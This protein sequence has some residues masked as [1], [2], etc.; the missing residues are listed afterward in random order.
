[1]YKIVYLMVFVSVY[2]TFL[3]C[4]QDNANVST[5]ELTAVTLNGLNISFDPQNGNIIKLSYPETGDI[6]IADAENAGII[7]IS[8]AAENGQT[9]ELLP[10]FSGKAQITQIES[11]VKIQWRNL[12]NEKSDEI[13]SPISTTVIFKT[14]PEDNSI[15]M[16]CQIENQSKKTIKQV[17]FPDF[18][19]IIAFD[20]RNEMQLTTSTLTSKPFL[21]LTPD[22]P[23]EY[24]TG[25]LVPSDSSM[26]LR[27]FD[28]GSLKRGISI[29]PKRW[30][31]EPRA[32]L[33]QVLSSSTGKLQLSCVHS[34]EVAPGGCWQ[35]CEYVLTPHKYGWANGVIPYRKWIRKN[36]KQRWQLPKHIAEDIGFR[37]L[38]MNQ[39]QPYD[40]QDAT[41][42]ADDL[43]K[44]AQESK[45]HGLREMVLWSWAPAFELPIPKP[46]AIIGTEQEFF[47]AVKKCREMGVD[48]S[49][50]ISF[51]L[52]VKKTAHKYGVKFVL[53]DTDNWTYHPELVPMFRPPYARGL[54]GVMVPRTNE[55]WRRE[56]LESCAA[57]SEKGL[58]IGW[59]VF[60]STED[61]HLLELIQ[62]VRETAKQFDPNSTL[63]GEEHYNL[64][65][66]C[67]YLDYTWNWSHYWVANLDLRPVVNILRP[68]MR[69]NW[70]INAS[71]D[72]TKYC[73]INN[74]FVNVW[75]S[76]L[77]GPDGTDYIV[78][79]PELSGALKQCSKLRKQF[80]EYFIDGTGIADC[81]LTNACKNANISAYVLP[82]SV[83][84]FVLNK[85]NEQ[86]IQLQCDVSPWIGKDGVYTVKKYNGDGNVIDVI[87][88]EKPDINLE[89]GVLKS[90]DI[91]LY[92]IIK[93]SSLMA[94]EKTVAPPTNVQ[95]TLNNINMVF[96]SQTGGIL[97][98]SSPEVGTFISAD[99]KQACIFDL[100][101]PIEKFEPLRVAP[102]FSKDVKITKN[103]DSITL[104]WGELTSS[105]SFFPV[106]GKI[107]A[108][109][110]LKV[111]K[112]DKSII[113][114][115]QINNQ[116]ENTIR[117][118]I[119]PDFFGVVPL[120]ASQ[121]G[122]HTTADI[123]S[124][125]NISK[126]FVLMHPLADDNFYAVR[127]NFVQYPCNTIIPWM[128][129][130][131]EKGGG[132]AVFSKKLQKD[133]NDII[134]M[135]LLEKTLELR[136]MFSH[137]VNIKAGQE[138]KSGDYYLT[139][140]KYGW[141]QNIQS[142]RS[143]LSE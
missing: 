35:S 82:E 18:K 129:L 140:H 25:G 31:W 138:W 128:D 61:N 72:I 103:E 89:T 88:A 92:E 30:G 122:F 43:P 19:G 12:A 34:V 54:Q 17:L 112:D 136:L 77:D 39:N 10:K 48:I 123:N 113:M 29:F 130:S 37:S 14:S 75:T 69:F 58:S 32:K 51:G 109:V 2:C 1:M 135:H 13:D 65:L 21:Q 36:V 73:C 11:G 114:T 127:N 81:I 50:F 7:G 99:R 134:M 111:A 3:A 96:D 139:P 44:L 80:L 90:S 116:S 22:T 57:I 141:T 137:Y 24:R 42:K 67:E 56:V 91:V 5:Q 47:D 8:Y 118:V 133:P 23:V 49:G 125:P 86:N 87:K 97:S 143:L 79:H 71:A 20:D 126:P 93:N 117:Q 52:A 119:F 124:T 78:N 15:I 83:L 59:D 98:M 102:H 76:K 68:Y 104:Y 120:N 94:A 105:R 55:L 40:R 106:P 131:S 27:W 60:D 74:I 70:N 108:T 46:F 33:R 101:Y 64:E 85:P 26:G 132:F 16:Q 63:C 53:N 107:S 41:W 100:A 6:L 9:V 62:K 142:F 45:A 121:L 115:C 28:I 95:I 66:D 38:W 110:T 4:G 84:I